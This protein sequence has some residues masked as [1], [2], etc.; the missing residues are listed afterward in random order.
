MQ[1]KTLMIFFIQRI[2]I[3][4][5]EV[6]LK[7]HHII[8]S[9]S[10]NFR[11][12]WVT[13]YIINIEQVQEFGLYMVTLLCHTSHALRPLDVNCFKPFK[14]TFKKEKDIAMVRNN[15]Y[16]PNKCTLTT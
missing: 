13:C 12:T 6:I 15:H 1:R 14:T 4:F 16:E 9:T 7:W 3:N 10:I 5:Q 2:C 11:W 8:L